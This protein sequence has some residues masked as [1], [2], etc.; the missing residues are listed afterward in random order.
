MKNY[1]LS[2]PYFRLI[3]GEG[4]LITAFMRTINFEIKANEL[5][6]EVTLKVL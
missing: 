6:A 3:V 5:A 4:L 2:V 1:I